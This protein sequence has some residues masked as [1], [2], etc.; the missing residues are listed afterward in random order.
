MAS[1]SIVSVGLVHV[2]TSL[3]IN[4]DQVLLSGV[5]SHQPIFTPP[6]IGA[7]SAAATL[8]LLLLVVFYKWRQVGE[9][10]AY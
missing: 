3:K 1:L 4:S 6:L 2:I 7:L 10:G 9:G 8:F 5:S